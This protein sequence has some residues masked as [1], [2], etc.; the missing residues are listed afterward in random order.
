VTRALWG[1]ALLLASTASAQAN[2]SSAPKAPSPQ[3]A[4]LAGVIQD[5]T[6]APIA[7]A[8]IFAD[9]R[10]GSAV[11]DDS[12]RF[13]LRGLPPG[14]SGFTITKIGYAPVSFETTLLPDS[15]IVLS[16]HLRSVQ[17]LDPV[18]VNAVRVNAYLVRTGFTE[19]KRLGTGSYLGPEQL[20]SL[21]PRVSTPAQ[22]L[23]DLRGIDVRCPKSDCVVH[24][25]QPPDCFWL[26]VDG[27]PLGTDQI[28]VVGLTP[29][30]IAAIEVY[31]R[32][33]IVPAE[34]E[35]A[36]PQKRGRGMS[37]AAG[38]GAIV[39]WTKSRVP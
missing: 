10:A 3:H 9:D 13:V 38:C 30:G 8:S 24:A 15:M 25:H 29:G 1:L 33:S 26:F 19:R 20:D 27:A 17:T 31:E 6:G 7:G 34:F 4:G 5:A 35:G 16:I 14:K 36:L 2:P 23:R 32:E 37:L 12:G 21:A 28:D 11:S 18:R 39:V 22:L